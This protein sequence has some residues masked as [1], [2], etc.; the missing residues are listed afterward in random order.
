[1]VHPGHLRRLPSTQTA[2]ERAG[3]RWLRDFTPDSVTGVLVGEEQT[4]CTWVCAYVHMHAGS[5]THTHKQ[6]H[7]KA[8]VKGEVSK[9]SSLCSGYSHPDCSA[10][11]PRRLPHLLHSEFQRTL[12]QLFSA[13]FFPLLFNISLLEY[14]WQLFKK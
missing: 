9:V 14:N 13:A 11:Q 10:S 8:E 3:C 7:V 5:C 4:R 2:D 1:M 6:D 12:R